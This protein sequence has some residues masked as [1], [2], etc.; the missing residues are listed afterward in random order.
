MKHIKTSSL[1]PEL[2]LLLECART[3]VEDSGA[4][5]IRALA[6]SN[7]DWADVLARAQEHGVAPLVDLHLRE[8]AAG[9]APSEWLGRLQ[10]LC[11]GNAFINLSMAAELFRVLETFRAQGIRA[12]PYKGPALAAQA[13]GD[14]SLRIFSDLDLIVGHCDVLRAGELLTAAGYRADFPAALTSSGKIPG[15]YVFK[16]EGSRVPIELHTE[17][18]LRYFPRRLDLAVL[19]HRLE[20]VSVGGREIVTF[21][22]EDMLPLL[23]VHGSKH[24]WDRLLWIADIAALVTRRR[25][26]DWQQ[27]LARARS[28]G[29][30]RMVLLGLCLAVETLG[31]RLPP[32]ITA[33]IRADRTARSLAHGIRMRYLSEDRSTP[34][35]LERAKFR[36]L[37][38]GS[39]FPAI[40]YFWR[41]TTAPTEEDWK[42]SS[43]GAQRSLKGLGRPIRLL[44]KYGLGLKRN[45]VADRAGHLPVPLWLA[46]RMLE[47]ADVRRQDV[48]YDLGCGDGQ[49]LVLAA[50]RYGARGVGVDVDTRRLREARARARAEGVVELV[51]FVE[52]DAKMVDLSPATVVTL[53]LGPVA[54]AKLV[55]QFR[56]QLRPGT[57]IVSGDGDIPGWPASRV[58]VARGPQGEWAEVFLWRLEAASNRVRQ[59]D[60][61]TSSS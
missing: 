54:N 14:L 15:Q 34:A 1:Q 20:S 31:A 48:I 9:V 57:R 49:I 59:D 27:A 11:Q 30:E 17:N 60:R 12:I 53:F 43:I 35:V 13:Y 29:A 50:K 47:F 4:A 45:Q 44:R 7:L 38:H 23:C 5:R 25:T 61:A 39:L 22:A 42:E 18:T 16:R 28:L 51:N 3:V 10:R 40:P 8:I 55:G 2:A 58:E 24:F 46:E 36:I 21:A 32:D 56:S 6:A 52:Q 37:M 33:R 19:A 41:L 26:L